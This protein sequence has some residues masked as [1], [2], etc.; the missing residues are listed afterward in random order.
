MS[1]RCLSSGYSPL[2]TWGLLQ[3]SPE[4]VP[5]DDVDDDDPSAYYF[6]LRTGRRDT[7]ELR[8]FLYLDLASSSA[9]SIAAQTQ[10][11]RQQTSHKRKTSMLSRSTSW[12][13]CTSELNSD[14]ILLLTYL[15]SR[16]ERHIAFTPKRV[17]PLPPK[18]AVPVVSRRPSRESLRNI[19]SPKPVPL[20]SLPEPPAVSSSAGTTLLP[21][22]PPSAE[23]QPPSPLPL[24]KGART[25]P[26]SPSHSGLRR[27]SSPARSESITSSARMRSR[28]D[29]LACLEGRGRLG[30]RGR[31]RGDGRRKSN[32]MSMSDGEDEEG[33]GEGN[34]QDT[35]VTCP[36]GEEMRIAP[37]I[38]AS[39]PVG[40]VV[41][42]SSA[43]TA[44]SRGRKRRSTLESW[45]PLRSFIDLKADS[46]ERVSSWKWRSFIEI[47]VA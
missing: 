10:R 19:P 39:S 13:F 38:S 20:T 26:P 35:V 47:G 12:T 31:G 42:A 7:V 37:T 34:R 8:S 40:N 32:F 28:M 27:A 3:T 4:T 2:F 30:L 36:G 15:H 33:D 18:L 6:T 46:E 43:S 16:R 11:S 25:A 5:L 1:T 23:S 24:Q 17:P 45:F 22:N 44:M 29:A 14:F 9:R 21:N 41:G